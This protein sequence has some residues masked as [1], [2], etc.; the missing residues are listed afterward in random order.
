MRSMRDWNHILFFATLSFRF[1][2]PI[3]DEKLEY[4]GPS[5]GRWKIT[6]RLNRPIRPKNR[7]YLIRWMNEWINSI[8]ARRAAGTSHLARREM[9]EWNL[10]TRQCAHCGV[11]KERPITSLQKIV[12]NYHPQPKKRNKDDKVEER[13]ANENVQKKD[14]EARECPICIDP[15]ITSEW[16]SV[17]LLR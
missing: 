10:R 1:G 14:S 13:L 7:A 8:V 5:T 17:W 11:C 12:S 4:I 3:G 15:V 16:G 6:N 2:S 9:P